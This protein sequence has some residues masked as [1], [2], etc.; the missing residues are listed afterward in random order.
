MRRTYPLLE[1]Y[2]VTISLFGEITEYFFDSNKINIYE[3]LYLEQLAYIKSYENKEK[4][5]KIYQSEYMNFMI[6]LN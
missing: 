3:F 6:G 4:L 5:F 2:V 1:G